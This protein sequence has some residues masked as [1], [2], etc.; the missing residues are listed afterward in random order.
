[1]TDLVLPVFLGLAAFFDWRYRRIP[2]LITFPVMAAGLI[3]Q[4][5]AGT[6]WAALTGMAGGFLLTV[7]PV[8]LRG[9]G[10]GDQKL[11]MA[12][13]A[14]SSWGDV[15]LFFLCS[16]GVCLLVMFCLPRIWRRLGQNLKIMFMGWIAHRQFWLPQT[17]HSALSFPY[18]VP[19]LGAYLVQLFFW[20]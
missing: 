19:L 12:V 2:N 3:Y 11:L 1:M 4:S 5:L 17:A 7:L 9:M 8:A 13:G 6:G 20:R 16:I 10:M 14:W 15:Y 18:A